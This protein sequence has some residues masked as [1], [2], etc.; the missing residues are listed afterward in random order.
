M[1]RDSPVT[2]YIDLLFWGGVFLGFSL[3]YRRTIGMLLYIIPYNVINL[4]SCVGRIRF[5]VAYNN[6]KYDAKNV[7]YCSRHERQNTSEFS[8][9]NFTLYT[10]AVTLQQCILYKPRLYK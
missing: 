10:H 4:F 3:L 1:V 8:R 9:S 6:F 7:H 2:V 5:M